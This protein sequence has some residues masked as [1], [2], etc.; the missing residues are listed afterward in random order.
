MRPIPLTFISFFLTLI[1]GCNGDSDEIDIENEEPIPLNMY[2]PPL[3]GTTWETVTASQLQWNTE[4]ETALNDYLEETNSKGFI[5]LKNG[6]I[7]FEKYFNG[8]DINAE[9]T[10]YSAAKS[11]TA[12]FVGIAQDEGILDINNKT[13]DYLGD[14][15]SQ[16]TPEKQDLITVRH[17]LTMTTGLTPHLGDYIPWICTLPACLDYT[18]DA[19]TSWAYHQGAYMLLQ[20]MI[21]QSSGISF[22]DY[23]KTKVSDKIGMQGNWTSTLGLNVYN[24]NTRS[25]ARF[26]LLILNEGKWDGTTIVGKSYFD[27]MTNTSQEINE[28]YGYLWWLNG[29]ETVVGTSSTEILSGPLVPNAPEDMIAALGANDQKI[30][31]VPSQ[32]LVVVRCGESA[33]EMQLGPS[34]FDNELWAKINAVIDQ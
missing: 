1:I 9:W 4:N 18:A 5:V 11:L 20:N 12:T 26:G 2:F 22:Q 16:L 31:V 24:S 29:K 21:T 15:W 32:E 25:M 8:H 23:C 7:V 34:S 13:S 27:E 28:S 14:D 33:G 10:W 3:E 6:R 19:G 17:H 30:Y